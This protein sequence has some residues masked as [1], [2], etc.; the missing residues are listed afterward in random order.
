MD[1]LLSLRLRRP[2]FLPLL[3]PLLSPPPFLSPP[4]LSPFESLGWAFLGSSSLERAPFLAAPD[5]ESLPF[6]FLSAAL[7]FPL[8]SDPSPFWPPAPF[9]VLLPPE[10]PLL[11]LGGWFPLPPLGVDGDPSGSVPF[12]PGFFDPFFLAP[13]W[14]FDL[15]SLPASP[16]FFFALAGCRFFDVGACGATSL[17]RVSFWSHTLRRRAPE[18]WASR[19]A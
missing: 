11:F 2:R 16:F 9:L 6:C 10:D 14:P 5:F 12:C 7:G 1:E 18:T 3:S 17:P 15:E 4:F 13:A 8:G 19:D